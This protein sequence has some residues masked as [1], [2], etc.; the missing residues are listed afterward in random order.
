MAASLASADNIISFTTTVSGPT[1]LTNMAAFLTAWDPGSTGGTSVV[2][3]DSTSPYSALSGF[4]SGVT[5]AS[6][7]SA[8]FTYT[9]NSYDIY[10]NGSIAGSFTAIAGETGVPSGHVWLDAYSALSLGGTMTALTSASEPTNDLFN[11]GALEPPADGPDAA[12]AHK[13]IGPL[14][15]NAT[16]APQT[17][18]ASAQSDLGCTIATGPGNGPCN[19]VPNF[20]GGDL[21]SVE[22]SSLLDFFVSTLTNTDT[23]FTSGNATTTN[24]TTATDVIT[25]AYDFTSVPPSAAPEPATMALMGGALIGLGLLRRRYRKS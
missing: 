2:A 16:S 8:G 18:S 15:P 1:D 10:V 11:G 20:I 24:H 22:G 4:E 23:Q 13:A 5:M 25:I 21:S 17:V 7:D 19:S 14:A 12:T 9:L 3:S 6:L